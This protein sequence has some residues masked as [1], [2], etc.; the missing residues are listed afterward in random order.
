MPNGYNLR[1]GNGRGSVAPEVVEKLR[2]SN[3]GKK[4]SEETRR[5][6]SELHRG[7]KLSDATR[8][9]LSRYWKGK[10]LPSAAR[11]KSL[12]ASVKTY[13]LLDPSGHPVIVTNMAAFCREHGLERSQMSE[14]T[15]GHKRSYK[16][17]RSAQP[18][19]PL[20]RRTT[21]R[22]AFAYKA[23]YLTG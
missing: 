18:I 20:P 14:V 4:A 10:P 6:L 22:K 23:Q 2:T 13:E 8:A 17:W 19:D 9:K 5:K 21:P 16:G 15:R 7:K 3:R 1:A 12:A 11:A